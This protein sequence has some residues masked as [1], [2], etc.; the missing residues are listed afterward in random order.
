MAS[1]LRDIQR[2]ELELLCE[3][4]RICDKYGIPY[5]LAQGTLLGAVRHQGFIPWDDD[6]DV[7]LRADDMERFAEAF[8]REAPQGYTF[9]R[10]Q[11]VPSVPYPWPK[12]RKKGTTSMP[13]RY[14]AI[15]LSWEICIDLF[16]YVDVADGR[17]AHAMAKLR[18]LIAK[19]MLGVT[20]TFYEDRVK[21]SSRLVR[22][23]PVRVRCA[24]AQRML[25]QL[26]RRQ[27]KGRDVLV[28]CR[29]GRFVRREWIEGPA[30]E[31]TFEGERFRAPSD[32]DAYLTGM[33]GDYRT[34]PPPQE[35]RGHDERMGDIIWD[36]ENSYQAYR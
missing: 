35:R 20:M 13:R 26:R 9:E 36:T 29:G 5:Y 6:A 28:F 17:L 8:F 14:Q 2:V 25:D 4:R 11:E 21:L 31:L 3:C 22:M 24:V 30:C 19:R 27:K 10:F 18:F 16:Q 1:S 32:P 12:L 23:L 7:L 34:P 15:P 33:F